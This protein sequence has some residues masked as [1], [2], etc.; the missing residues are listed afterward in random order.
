MAF[1]ELNSAKYF[2][3]VAEYVDEAILYQYYYHKAS[4]FIKNPS[5]HEVLLL[6]ITEAIE[7]LY[8]INGTGNFDNEFIKEYYRDTLH[9]INK[10]NADRFEERIENL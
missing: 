6:R 8:D 5:K 4:K 9:V 2:K 1:K 3:S 10:I 7:S